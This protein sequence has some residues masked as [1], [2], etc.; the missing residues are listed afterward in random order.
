MS[1]TPTISMFGLSAAARNT[2]RPIRPNP[3]IPIFNAIDGLLVCS[4]SPPQKGPRG[5]DD[6][7]QTKT[8][9]QHA[10]DAEICSPWRC[11]PK[12]DVPVLE[13]QMNGAPLPLAGQSRAISPIR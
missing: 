2:N 1:F 12:D 3:L 5:A 6:V 13:E 11:L 9:G 4:S 10:G 7:K 8:I